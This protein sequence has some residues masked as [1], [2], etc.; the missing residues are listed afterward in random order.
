MTFLEVYRVI[1]RKFVASNGHLMSSNWLQE[2]MTTSFM[3][4]LSTT[5]SSLLV[6][7]EVTLQLLRPYHGLLTNMDF[8]QVEVAP[9]I[10]ASDSGTQPKCKKLMQSK[11]DLK[12]VIYI[13]AKM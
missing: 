10:D 1:S 11:L 8:W 7:L 12:F 3:F 6:S 5:S 2:E 13:S 4:G 9:L